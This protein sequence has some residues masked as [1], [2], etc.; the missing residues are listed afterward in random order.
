MFF[1]SK[2]TRKIFVRLRLIFFYK[3][4]FK[5]I[6]AKTKIYPSLFLTPK[7]I[8]VGHSVVIWDYARIEGI[9]SYTFQRFSPEISIGNFVTIQQGLH[10]TCAQDLVIGDHTDIMHHVTITDIEHSMDELNKQICEQKLIVKP[11]KI[12]KYCFIGAGARI[13]AGTTLGDNCVVGANSVV[14]GEFK[15]GS[16]IVGAPARVLKIRS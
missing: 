16:V 15:A 6:G 14:K 12:G 7:F 8:E 13:L 11:T 3:F 9:D 2:I 5:K 10:L 4:V 1:Q